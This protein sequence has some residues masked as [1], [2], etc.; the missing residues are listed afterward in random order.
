MATIA[1]VQEDL[2][3]NLGYEAAGSV[4][5]ANAFIEACNAY[6]ILWPTASS[7]G[8]TSVAYDVNQIRMLRDEAKQWKRSHSS[9]S[10]RVTFL[11]VT[12]DF[13]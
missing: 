12:D 10:G 11:S 7:E 13:R 8:G 9:P 5:M 2:I 4:S 1:T 6:L 3:A